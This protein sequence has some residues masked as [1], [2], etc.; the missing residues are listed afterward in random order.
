[1]ACQFCMAEAGCRCNSL[2]MQPIRYDP[3]EN[4]PN[5]DWLDYDA[6]RERDQEREEME[7]KREWEI[8]KWE[9]DRLDR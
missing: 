6:E 3:Q 5:P 9:Q 8:E 4:P 1:M 7:L 2:G